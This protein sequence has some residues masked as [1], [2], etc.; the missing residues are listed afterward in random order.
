MLESGD[1]EKTS[2]SYKFKFEN[3]WLQVGGFL[4]KIKGGG[5]TIQSVVILT[6]ILTQKHKL[7]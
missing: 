7:L 6:S 5:K 2:H 4:D 3:M 1:W